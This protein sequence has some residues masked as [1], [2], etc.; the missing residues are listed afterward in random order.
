M[1]NLRENTLK[2]SR[3]IRSSGRKSLFFQRKKENTIIN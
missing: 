3:E 1:G 2:N